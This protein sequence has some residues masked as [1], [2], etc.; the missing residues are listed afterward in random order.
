MAAFRGEIWCE[1][2]KGLTMARQVKSGNPAMDGLIT[3][4]WRALTGHGDGRKPAKATSPVRMSDIHPH[5]SCARN[6]RPPDFSDL[7][8]PETPDADDGS[9]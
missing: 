3:R 4:A 9:R 5:G 7:L 2:T 1:P 6:A 8:A